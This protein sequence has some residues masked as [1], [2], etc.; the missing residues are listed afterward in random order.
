[1]RLE[2]ESGQLAEVTSKAFYWLRGA[3]FRTART[4]R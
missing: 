1:M 4:G 3:G 2:A